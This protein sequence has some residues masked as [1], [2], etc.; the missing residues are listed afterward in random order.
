[1]R[2][3]SR[4]GFG[5]AANVELHAARRAAKRARY[6]AEAVSPV[7]GKPARRFAT[8]MKTMQSA[9]GTHQDAVIARNTIREI[10]VRAHLEGEHVHLRPAA[11]A[12]HLRHPGF[13]APRVAALE[14]RMP[15]R[16]PQMAAL[17]HGRSG[18]RSR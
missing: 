5:E 10:G 6:A 12:R 1:M 18:Q 7:Y 13:G 15:P 3:A 14:A 17:G 16:V 8:Q 4:A 11:R 2:L 9:L